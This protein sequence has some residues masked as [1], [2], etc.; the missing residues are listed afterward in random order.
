MTRTGEGAPDDAA[1]DAF[2]SEEAA[3]DHAA[4]WEMASSV[5]TRFDLSAEDAKQAVAESIAR[6]HRGGRIEVVFYSF[7]EDR[8]TR[9]VFDLD[10]VLS[11]QS[12]WSPRPINLVV[13][14]PS[15]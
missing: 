2:I 9:S 3:E 7:D 11:D 14:R 12:I 4:I 15:D 5:S 1:I 10:E 13:F 8:R 6:L